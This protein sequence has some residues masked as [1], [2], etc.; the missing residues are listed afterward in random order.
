MSDEVVEAPPKGAAD[1]TAK[2]ADLQDHAQEAL[3]EGKKDDK[4]KTGA[5]DTKDGEEKRKGETEDTNGKS[6]ADEDQNE[7]LV[8]DKNYSEKGARQSHR[9]G[10]PQKGSYR[11]GKNWTRGNV[12]DPSKQRE[13]ND[14]NEIRKQV[15][16]SVGAIL[17]N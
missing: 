17:A 6:K 7:K 2:T 4:D 5:N 3:E 1:A 14:P 11:K 10:A 15:C 16:H 12:F 9:S 13:T 8:K